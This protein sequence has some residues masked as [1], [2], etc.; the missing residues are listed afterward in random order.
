M[1]KQFQKRAVS[2]KFENVGMEKEQ[3]VFTQKKGVQKETFV[4]T[5]EDKGMSTFPY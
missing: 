5:L 2:V 1:T 3:L 4:M